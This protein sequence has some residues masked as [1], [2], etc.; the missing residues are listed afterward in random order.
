[1]KRKLLVNLLSAVA[2]LF[3]WQAGFSRNLLANGG[4]E[5]RADANTPAG[6]TTVQGITQD[7]G[8]CHC[9]WGG[10]LCQANWRHHYRT[11]FVNY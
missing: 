8:N 6:W 4:M 11:T 3:F 1:M 7:T 5:S 10:V 2:I 9:T